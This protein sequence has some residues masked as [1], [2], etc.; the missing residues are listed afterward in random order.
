MARRPDRRRCTGGTS[1]AIVGRRTGDRSSR[2]SAT[3]AGAHHHRHRSVGHASSSRPE[4]PRCRPAASAERWRDSTQRGWP[5]PS[6]RCGLRSRTGRGVPG[7]HDVAAGGSVGVRHPGVGPGVGRVL[8]PRDRQGVP[9]GDRRWCCGMRGS[10]A[11]RV[12]GRRR[13]DSDGRGVCVLRRRDHVH[14]GRLGRSGAD[15]EHGDHDARRR[16][17]RSS[18]SLRR[19]RFSRGRTSVRA[20]RGAPTRWC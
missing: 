7:A 1:G 6:R 10:P 19:A 5:Q 9:P 17:A 15:A 2:T 8:R 3:R 16:V 12:L 11:G 20:H 4:A 18:G 14:R 13:R